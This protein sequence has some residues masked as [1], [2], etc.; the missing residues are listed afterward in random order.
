M[1]SN[2][3]GQRFSCCFQEYTHPP[4]V[5]PATLITMLSSLPANSSFASAKSQIGTED[6]VASE[7][8]IQLI[9][10]SGI[11]TKQIGQSSFGG[12]SLNS[13]P[14][15]SSAALNFHSFLC[16][17]RCFFWHSAL[18]YLTVIQALHALRLAPPSPPHSAQ[19]RFISLPNIIFLVPT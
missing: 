1:G 15:R 13:V 16:F 2:G 7:S 11:G 10:F 12:G 18:Q 4:Q 14:S 6:I 8:D 3:T 17:G 9:N 19:T 5:L